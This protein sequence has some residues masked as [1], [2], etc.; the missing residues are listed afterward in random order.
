MHPETEQETISLIFQE[1]GYSSAEYIL[2]EKPLDRR[3][4]QLAVAVPLRQVCFI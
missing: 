3:S 2:G 4:P 1:V